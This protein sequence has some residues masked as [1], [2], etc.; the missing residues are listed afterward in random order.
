M[1][2]AKRILPLAVALLIISGC[3]MHHRPDHHGYGGMGGALDRAKAD[4]STLIQ[5]TVQDPAKA[6]QAEGIIGEIVAEVT[7]SRQQ[8]RQFHQ[9]LYKLNADYAAAPEEFLGILDGLNSRRMQAASNILGLRFRMKGL[10]TEQ[11][12]KAFT[13]GMAELRGRYR[14]KGKS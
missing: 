12:W 5:K 11:E 1:R 9:Q 6:E 4:M 13:D 3:G 2:P 10:M 14:S 7:R 8:N